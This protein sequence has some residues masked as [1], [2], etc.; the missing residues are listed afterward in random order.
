M[1]ICPDTSSYTPNTNM[2]PPKMEFGKFYVPCQRG[3]FQAMLLLVGSSSWC[4]FKSGIFEFRDSEP[5]VFSSAMSTLTGK[6]FHPHSRSK[7]WANGNIS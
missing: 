3:D 4:S 2:E 6:S 5:H 7:G 1:I